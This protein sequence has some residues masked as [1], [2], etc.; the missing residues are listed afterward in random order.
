MILQSISEFPF[1]NGEV[2]SYIHTVLATS[3][4]SIYKNRTC[5]FATDAIM[6]D[7]EKSLLWRIAYKLNYKGDGKLVIENK[8][9]V[10]MGRKIDDESESNDLIE[11]KSKHFYCVKYDDMNIFD[12]TMRISYTRYNEEKKIMKVF[13]MDTIKMKSSPKKDPFFYNCCHVSV[14]PDYEFESSNT[15]MTSYVAKKITSYIRKESR[16]KK[17]D[18]ARRKKLTGKSELRRLKKIIDAVF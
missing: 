2:P 10:Y 8:K 12:F 15:N 17:A 14:M 1:R 6:L 13:K 9:N 3:G 5:Q 18:E 7:M 11:L 4:P 16:E